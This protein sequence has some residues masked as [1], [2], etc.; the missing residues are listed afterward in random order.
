M[1]RPLEAALKEALTDESASLDTTAAVTRLTAVRYRTTGGRTSPA[2]RRS[3]RTLRIWRR[4]SIAATTLVAAVV[5]AVLVFAGGESSLVPLAYAGWSAVP[6]PAPPAQIA[7]A[8]KLCR[9]RFANIGTFPAQVIS[10]AHLVLTDG[11]GRYVAALWADGSTTAL[12]ITDGR[13]ADTTGGSASGQVLTHGAQLGF[14]ALGI[15]GPL[16]GFS[17]SDD[18]SHLYGRAAPDIRQITVVFAGHR[19]VQ[20]T[21]ENGWYFAWWPN[22]EHPI[23]IKAQTPSRT[24]TMHLG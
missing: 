18:E 4:A 8:A 15:G 13:A 14:P 21:V 1:R 11:R 5:A 17:G 22:S 2:V 24:R 16:R 10:P 6:R 23:A 12:C 3:S 9:A 19:S 7:A 20:A